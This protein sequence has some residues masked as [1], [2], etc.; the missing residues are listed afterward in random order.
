MYAY[1]CLFQGPPFE[2]GP[3]VRANLFRH[4][5]KVGMNF[6]KH[7]G[8]VCDPGVCDVIGLGSCHG[9]LFWGLPRGGC[10]QVLSGWEVLLNFTPNNKG[11]TPGPQCHGARTGHAMSIGTKTK[12][13]RGCDTHFVTDTDTIVYVEGFELRF[14]SEDSRAR[15]HELCYPRSGPGAEVLDL[16]ARTKRKVSKL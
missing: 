7:G 9:P 10:L 4:R 8:C 15:C 5:F 12:V 2:D 3:S 16:W 1:D 11:L 6:W 14:L 13:P